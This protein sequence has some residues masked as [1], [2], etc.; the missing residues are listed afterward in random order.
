MSQDWY[1]DIIDMHLAQGHY[2][3][4]RPSIPPSDVAL[5]RENLIDEEMGEVERALIDGNLEEIADGIVDS[6]VVLLGTA[7]SYGIDI[8]PI[9]DEVHATNMNKVGGEK[10]GD[11][12]QLKPANWK[13]PDIVSILR[14]QGAN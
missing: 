7:I 8:R 2:I 6:I 10:R 12:K 5:L 13:P 4:V 14:Q 9:W 11:G 1:R 3:G